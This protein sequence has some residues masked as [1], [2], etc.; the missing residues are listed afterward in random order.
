MVEAHSE[1]RRRER[2]RTH[3]IPLVLPK[4][5]AEGLPTVAARSS[6]INTRRHPAQAMPRKS[7]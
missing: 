4:P 7:K 3:P 2:E 5:G 1:Y 6:S